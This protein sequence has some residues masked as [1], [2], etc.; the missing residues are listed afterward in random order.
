M[1]LPR[2][3]KMMVNGMES[4]PPY[5]AYSIKESP[6]I[7]LSRIEMLARKLYTKERKKLPPVKR[8]GSVKRKA[9]ANVFF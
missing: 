2:L 7:Y 3:S 5:I 8:Q 1:E 9:L 4:F 6:R